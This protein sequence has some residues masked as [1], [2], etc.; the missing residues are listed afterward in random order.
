M[1]AT[2][3]V[4]LNDA[5]RAEDFMLMLGLNEGIDRLAMN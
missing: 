5:K 3:V 2:C 4:Q 1:R